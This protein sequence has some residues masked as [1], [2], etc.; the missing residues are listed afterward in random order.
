MLL[1]IHDL[2][3][4]TCCPA[5][6]C[7][8]VQAVQIPRGGPAGSE[9]VRWGRHYP[10]QHRRQRCSAGSPRRAFGFSSNAPLQN[11]GFPP[12]AL[13]RP[14]HGDAASCAAGGF[15]R[16]GSAREGAGEPRRWS[17]CHSGAGEHQRLYGNAELRMKLRY[18]A[19]I[20]VL[21][22]LRARMGRA[23]P[24]GASRRGEP[25]P[26]AV[27]PQQGLVVGMGGSGAGPPW[28]RGTR[29]G[30]H[31]GV[32][33][34]GD[35]PRGQ[36]AVLRRLRG[37]VRRAGRRGRRCR[38]LSAAALSP[39]SRC[40]GAVRTDGRWRSG[41][42]V[43]SR[44]APSPQHPARVQPLPSAFPALSLTLSAPAA[45]DDGCYLTE[46]PP[47]VAAATW[48]SQPRERRFAGTAPLRGDPAWPGAAARRGATRLRGGLRA[49]TAPQLRT[50]CRLCSVPA[51]DAVSARM[52]HALL[53]VSA[54]SELFYLHLAAA[55]QAVGSAERAFGRAVSTV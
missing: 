29:A 40:C 54:G 11:S 6:C 38:L 24:G 26:K 8:G 2:Q 43:P 28:C 23:G 32:L 45:A 17:G 12:C 36:P 4:W 50:H 16:M 46:P 53:F 22:S 34:S 55:L 18:V 20:A 48:P 19:A 42:A 5:L 10:G 51:A 47:A 25:F 49:H 30:P 52:I 7:P 9:P 39:T 3:C 37:E 1:R 33:M 35:G 21:C 31:L 15:P 13:H 44:S 27:A 14:Q 41:A